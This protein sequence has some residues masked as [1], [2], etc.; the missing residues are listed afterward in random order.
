[1]GLKT[2]QSAEKRIERKQVKN[3]GYKDFDRRL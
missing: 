1:M 2:L 3:G